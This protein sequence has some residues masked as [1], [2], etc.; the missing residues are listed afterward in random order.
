MV[1]PSLKNRFQEP[2]WWNRG[3][4]LNSSLLSTVPD[5]PLVIWLPAT[6]PG[7][8]AEDDPTTLVPAPLWETKKK[9]MA[10]DFPKL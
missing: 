1:T 2:A 8:A 3:L 6:I 10:L 5:I 4:S 9:L 7:K